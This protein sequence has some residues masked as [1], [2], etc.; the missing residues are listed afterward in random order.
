MKKKVALLLILFCCIFSIKAKAED[1]SL[2]IESKNIINNTKSVDVN[3]EIPEVKSTNKLV[4]DIFIK[5]DS[6]ISKWSDN[7]IK[8]ANADLFDAKYV[9]NSAFHVPYNTNNLLSLNVMNYYYAGGAHGLSNLI[10]YN[11]D[12]KTG[13]A[14]ALK[15]LFIE[16]YDYKNLINTKIKK[17]IS[18]DKNTY[19]SGGTEFKGISDNQEFYISEQGITV[20]FQ[21]YE[22]APYA[23]GI[24]YFLIPK[25][26]IS[27][28]L[29]IKF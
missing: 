23:A 22:I 21:T 2:I 16:G 26:E 29:K 3:I 24:R 6:D 19:F 1:N 25:D 12:I 10:S 28:N 20:Y 15:D 9:V 17:Y 27:N 13:K 7:L 11:Y 18:A 14:L 8:E 4:T 5:I